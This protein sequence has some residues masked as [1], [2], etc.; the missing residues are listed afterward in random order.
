MQKAGGQADT[1]EGDTTPPK[2]FPEKKPV[3]APKWVVH[4]NC[5]ADLK[6]LFTSDNNSMACRPNRAKPGSGKLEII[7]VNKSNIQTFRN[8]HSQSCFSNPDRAFE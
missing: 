4:Y 3:R 7:S 5:G 6:L 2:L 1:M 8:R